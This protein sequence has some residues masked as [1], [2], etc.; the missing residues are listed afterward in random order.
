MQEFEKFKA[1]PA[2][3][4]A[5]K[6]MLKTSRRAGFYQGCF[7]KW[8]KKREEQQWDLLIRVAPELCKKHA[9]VPNHLRSALGISVRK[10]EGSKFSREDGIHGVPDALAI[11]VEG[12]VLEMLSTGQEVTLSCVKKVLLDMISLWNE[13]IGDFRK[14]IVETMEQQATGQNANGDIDGATETPLQ[15]ALKILQPCNASK[16][17]SAVTNLGTVWYVYIYIHIVFFSCFP[18]R[19]SIG[20]AHVAV[21]YG[22][23]TCTYIYIYI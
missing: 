8:Q 13:C 19:S 12:L 5:E 4:H 18:N 9:E 3:P 21:L 10:H 16:H 7:S 2:I 23:S 22:L 20:L 15:T 1:D 6:H 17:P 11:A 14:D